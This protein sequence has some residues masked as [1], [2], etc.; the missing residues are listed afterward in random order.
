MS[1][2]GRLLLSV[3]VIAWMNATLQPC[4]MAME[5]APTEAAQSSEVAEQNSHHGNAASQLGHE[6]PPCP[7]CPPS[8]SHDGDACAVTAVTDCEI[9]P[10][11]KPGERILKADFSDGF[12]AALSNYHFSSLDFVPTELLVASLDCTKPK[13]VVGP[14]IHLRNCVFLK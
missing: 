9:L 5:L 6:G 2:G 7:H 4:L 13:Y 1:T 10:Q 8:M 12:D 14:S 3:V 11:A